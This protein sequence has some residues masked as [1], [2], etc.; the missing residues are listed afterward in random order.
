MTGDR[1]LLRFDDICPTM[2]WEVWDSIE[3]NL[4]QHDVRPILA[5]IPDNRDP[6]LMHG[7]ALPDFW[8]RV[9]G[10]QARGY[11]IGLHGYQHVYVNQNPGMVGLTKQSEFAGL[12]RAEQEAKLEKAFAIFKEQGV[13]PDVWVAP[14]H[15]FDRTTIAIL[16][17]HGLNV[18]SDG[19]WPRP[20]LEEGRTFWVPQQLW[21]FLPRSSGIW[22]VCCHHSEWSAQRLE[23]FA[24]QLAEYQSRMTDL[25]A[26]QQAFQGRSITLGDRILARWEFLWRHNIRDFLA[27]LRRR[28]MN[29]ERA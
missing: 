15:S 6:K 3:R 29:T 7:P 4:V 11:T 26:V 16:A 20:F 22:T 27:G 1:Y 21:G 14:S 2:N 18:I 19:L 10:W 17:E 24:R 9:R 5:V 12:S 13:R 28:V 25:P 23:T 8:E